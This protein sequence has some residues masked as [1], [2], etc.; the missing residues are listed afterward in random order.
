[1]QSHHA[2]R[3]FTLGDYVDAGTM[4]AIDAADLARGRSSRAGNILIVG[5]QWVGKNGHC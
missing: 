4:R 3:F 2:R 1:L 5:A